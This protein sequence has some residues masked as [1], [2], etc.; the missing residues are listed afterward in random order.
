MVSPGNCC[1]I[2]S[3]RQNS[4]CLSDLHQYRL[5]CSLLCIH[6]SQ[7]SIFFS[8]HV[9]L[10][11]VHVSQPYG[12][13]GK[14]IAFTIRVFVCKLTCLSFHIFS[15]VT[16]LLGAINEFELN[17]FE[18]ENITLEMH[19]VLYLY[20]SCFQKLHLPPAFSEAS[21]SNSAQDKSK[22]LFEQSERAGETS[23]A[24]GSSSVQSKI[25]F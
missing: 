1:L 20:I 4:S 12:I 11:F 7:V 9:S 25:D 18:F 21:S 15:S 19:Y 16:V 13:T 17:D 22:R 10:V 14:I 6:I 2:P 3:Q 24:C 5:V 23:L 8:I